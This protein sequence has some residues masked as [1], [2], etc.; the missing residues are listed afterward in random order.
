MFLTQ[1]GQVYKTNYQQDKTF[2]EK[3]DNPSNLGIVTEIFT[4]RGQ[5]I[6][7]IKR[8]FFFFF[9]KFIFNLY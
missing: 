8:S 2:I 7:K 5:S 1:N 6:F 4:G 9:Q 3:M